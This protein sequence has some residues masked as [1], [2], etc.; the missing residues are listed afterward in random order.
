MFSPAILAEARS[1]GG[2]DNQR[3]SPVEFMAA[4]QAG[5]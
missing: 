5:F 4:G 2:L 1:F 3:F